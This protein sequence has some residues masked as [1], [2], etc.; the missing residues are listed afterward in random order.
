MAKRKYSIAK[1]KKVQPM[2]LKLNFIMLPE[3]Q[4]AYIDIFREVSKLSRKFIRQGQIAAIGNVR[5]TMPP[6]ASAAIGSA[7]YVSAMQNTWSVSN[8]WEKSFHMWNRQQK[9]AIEDSGSESAVAR[10]RD[11]K[12]FLDEG[13]W[14]ANDP[15][16]S[17]KKQL[18]AVNLGPF[19]TTGPFPSSAIATSAVK[20]GEWEYSQI[21]IPND[22]AVGNTVEYYLTMHGA[23]N[24]AVGTYAGT[25]GMV[26]G[27]AI[28]RAM[29]Q[30]P[31]PV[32]PALVKTSWMSEMF[33]VGD[34]QSD[35][36]DNAT[37][38]NDNLPY[39]QNEYPGGGSNYVHPENKAWLLNRS[40]VGVTQF[41][42][43]GMVAPCGLL[44][45]DTINVEDGLDP[46][47]I[48]IELLPGHER[49]LLSAH[50]RDM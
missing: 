42:L 8:S 29:P 47:L 38:R 1:T 11:F 48:E 15:A 49:G 21:V 50:M 35:I 14:Q 25:K 17:L 20:E 3:T 2:S 36:V 13:H 10:F 40:T 7:L 39:D 6:A 24:V 45:I 30:S 43:G 44:R 27:Y 46:I 5:I 34:N 19:D 41:N 22:G 31:D 9:E 32:T 37:A 26:K 16:G 4:T 12:V 18:E 23:D 33:D 28:S